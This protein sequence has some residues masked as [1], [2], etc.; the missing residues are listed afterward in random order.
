MSSNWRVLII[1]DDEN[2]CSQVKVDATSGK[3]LPA[4]GQMQ[5]EDCRTFDSALPLLD[6]TRFDFLILDLGKSRDAVSGDDASGGLTVFEEIKKRRFVPVVFYTALAHHVRDLETAFVRVVEKTEGLPGL[7]REIK[8]VFETGLPNLLRHIEE[9][10]RK[11]M[12]DF[13]ENSW[14]NAKSCYEKADLTYLLARRLAHLLGRSSIRQFLRTHGTPSPTPQNIHPVEMYLRPVPDTTISSGY[15]LKGRI[16]GDDAYWVVLTPSCDFE[17]GHAEHVLLAKCAK[18]DVQPEYTEYVQNRNSESEG[19]LKSLV[20]D[21]RTGG[22]S[23]RYKYLPSTFFIPDLV[24]DLQSLKQ[25]PRG[26]L[27]LDSIE[28]VAALDSPFTEGLLTQ[29]SHYYGRVGTPDLDIEL[30]LSRIGESLRSVE[31]Q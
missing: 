29:F 2:I 3:L 8:K 4:V 5:A 7:R 23:Y 27:E 14:H 11:Y 6:S 21:H 22:Q 25:V 19:K 28:K 30:V 20:K 9:E 17:H 13:V 15:I 12:W 10:Q 26:Q 18:L 31:K 1:E 16:D 24:V